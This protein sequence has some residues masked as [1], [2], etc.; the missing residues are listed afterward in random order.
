MLKMVKKWIQ[1]ACK[2]IYLFSQKFNK[3]KEPKKKSK[4]KNKKL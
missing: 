2:K 4:S 1:K 3:D